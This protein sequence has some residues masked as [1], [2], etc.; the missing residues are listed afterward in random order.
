MYQ[1]KNTP[2]FKIGAEFPFTKSSTL[3]IGVDNFS[4]AAQ[5]RVQNVI[6]FHAKETIFQTHS[7]ECSMP[8]HSV[9]MFTGAL[10]LILVHV[11]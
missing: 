1:L 3:Q 10:K 11:E 7:E 5:S 2:R 9:T 8:G 6:K 4:V